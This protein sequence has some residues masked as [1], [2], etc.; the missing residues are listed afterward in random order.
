MASRGADRVSEKERGVQE[1]CGA[2]LKEPRVMGALCSLSAP[3][4]CCVHL[5]DTPPLLALPAPPIPGEWDQRAWLRGSQGLGHD[6]RVFQS[7][8]WALQGSWALRV[9]F[10]KGFMGHSSR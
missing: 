7:G 9:L 6:T 1:S 10:P 5:A 3:L 2:A 4:L 8:Q